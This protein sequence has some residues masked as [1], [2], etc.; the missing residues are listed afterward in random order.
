ME[1]FSMRHAVPLALLIGLIAPHAAQAMNDDSPSA[2]F[3]V[4]GNLGWYM[5]GG[6]DLEGTHDGL[7]VETYGGLGVRGKIG[8]DL[9]VGFHFSRHDL[10]LRTYYLNLYGVYAE[11]RVVFRADRRTVWPFAGARI[12]WMRRVAQNRHGDG[13][14]DSDGYAIGGI[15]GVDIPIAGPLIFEAALSVTYVSFGPIMSY[16]DDDK[17]SATGLQF[18][19]AYPILGPGR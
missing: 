15:A 10:D 12:G 14:L 9:N 13:S 8:F 19:V 6:E 16:G 5:I 17:G 7:G 18:G 4:G 3:G 1:G 11:P 2:Y